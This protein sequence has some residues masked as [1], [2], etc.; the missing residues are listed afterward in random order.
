MTPFREIRLEIKTLTTRLND[1]VALSDNLKS[2]QENARYYH[3]TLGTLV[4]AKETIKTNAEAKRYYAITLL[5]NEELLIT[6]LSREFQQLLVKS[7]YIHPMYWKIDA[8]SFEPTKYDEADKINPLK[9]R[10]VS[11]H[12]LFKNVSMRYH[13]FYYF[14]EKSATARRDYLRLELE[15]LT[16]LEQKMKDEY[17]SAENAAH[18]MENMI[19][20]TWDEIE[21]ERNRIYPEIT[22]YIEYA[23]TFYTTEFEK[24]QRL[25]EADLYTAIK[26]R[27][28]K[29]FHELKNDPIQ[30]LDSESNKSEHKFPFVPEQLCGTSSLQVSCRDGSSCTPDTPMTL[31][32]IPPKLAGEYK[33]HSV[34]RCHS[35][36]C[37]SHEEMNQLCVFTPAPY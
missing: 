35:I 25:K 20:E 19:A 34:D 32:E 16:P 10:K 14:K 26:T 36:A 9:G 11:A 22:A 15:R 2:V 24:V 31:D 18:Q 28:M 37:S 13:S 5:E 4:C 30:F 6:Y 17:K 27:P 7:D 1:I 21:K 8:P 29:K 33:L 23:R 12:N 3:E